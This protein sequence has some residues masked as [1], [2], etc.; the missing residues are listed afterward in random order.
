MMEHRL[1]ATSNETFLPLFDDENRYLVLKGGGGSGKS[2]FAGRKILERSLNEEGH[3]FLVCRKVG[4]TLRHS[5]FRQLL[6]QLGQDYPDAEFKANQTDMRIFFPSTQ[7]EIIFSGLDDVEKLKSIY[8]ITGIWIEEASEL[9]EGDFNQL[10]IRLRGETAYYKQIIL[11]FN[12]VNVRHWLKGR[13]FDEVPDN[14]TVHESTYK[15]NRFLDEEAKKVLEGFADTDE[16]YYAVYCLGQWGVT[17]K[18][19]FPAKAVTERLSDAPEPLRVGYFLCEGEKYPD[20][21]VRFVED[22]NGPVRI[23]EEPVPGHPYVIGGDPAGDG[24][25][26]FVLQCVDNV[27]KRQAATFRRRNIDED[28][29]AKQAFCMGI[30]YNEALLAMESNW[31]TFP[32]LEL[33]RMRYPRQ[34]VR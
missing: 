11:T 22:E 8:N 25:D 16:Y 24:S 28:E 5:C 34:Y 4:R 23:Y 31:S 30:Y 29:Y 2:I 7:S 13:F 3:R 12:P 6:G 21:T 17:G 33:E 19:V 9:L 15:D 14:A 1:A 10:D 27:K 32:I 18:T 26:R 20:A